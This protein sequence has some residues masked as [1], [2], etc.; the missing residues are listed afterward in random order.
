MMTIDVTF[1]NHVSQ[2][3]CTLQ[4]EVIANLSVFRKKYMYL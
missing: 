2:W 1:L 4:L 3:S